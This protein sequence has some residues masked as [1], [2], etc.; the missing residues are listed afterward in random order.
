MKL[1]YTEEFTTLISTQVLFLLLSIGCAL[2]FSYSFYLTG[3]HQRLFVDSSDFFL[4]EYHSNGCGEIN[5]SNCHLQFVYWV[6]GTICW[7]WIRTRSL[8]NPKWRMGF[9]YLPF[10]ACVSEDDSV[11]EHKC[12]WLSLLSFQS[13]ILQE[14]QPVLLLLWII[15]LFI[16]LSLLFSSCFRNRESLLFLN[17]APSTTSRSHILLRETVAIISYPTSIERNRQQT[18]RA[19]IWRYTRFSRNVLFVKWSQNK[20]QPCVLIR[21]WNHQAVEWVV[22]FLFCDE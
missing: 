17:I 7:N 10:I 16:L 4:R 13:S 12:K 20:T 6:T 2:R 22:F 18:E 3:S 11:P 1:P 19:S 8:C 5:P 15:L 21:R 9:S 14:L